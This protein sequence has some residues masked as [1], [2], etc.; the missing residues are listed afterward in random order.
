MVDTVSVR[1]AF[2]ILKEILHGSKFKKANIYH[3]HI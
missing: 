2:Q 1:G 3:K